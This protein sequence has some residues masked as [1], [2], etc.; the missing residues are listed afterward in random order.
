M[1]NWIS[2]LSGSIR[3]PLETAKP[4]SQIEEH[5]IGFVAHDT[6]CYAIHETCGA[7]QKAKDR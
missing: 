1:Q 3:Q 5:E 7:F 2:L 4:Y 6:T